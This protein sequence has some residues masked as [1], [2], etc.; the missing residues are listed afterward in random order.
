MAHPNAVLGVSCKY[1]NYLALCAEIR[2]Y[3]RTQIG[4]LDLC[5]DAHPLL[6]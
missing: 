3:L 5:G 1:Q 2:H 6:Y 4:E